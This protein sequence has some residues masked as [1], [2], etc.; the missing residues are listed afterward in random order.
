[1]SILLHP[2]TKQRLEQVLR[3]GAYI[4]HGKQGAGRLMAVR[5]VLDGYDIQIIGH[6]D[7]SIKIASIHNIVRQLNLKNSNEKYAII[8]DD[9][10]RMTHA[11]QNALL[12]TL[13][14]LPTY[15]T[16]ILIAGHLDSLLPTITSRTHNLYFKEPSRQSLLEWLK[17][18][19]IDHVPGKVEE[20]ID[21]H[22]PLP[23]RILKELEAKDGDGDKS[24]SIR[25]L[26]SDELSDRLEAASQLQSELPEVLDDIIVFVRKQLRDNPDSYWSETVQLCLE[27]KRLVDAHANKRHVLDVIALREQVLWQN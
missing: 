24:A 5:H 21:Y 6:E 2:H 13:E 11:A 8:I 20:L 18:Q 19:H 16:V 3:P 27:A 12:K 22:G 17:E 1:M 26:F 14:E 9:A 4:V 15:A 25:A 7:G 23:A 10:E